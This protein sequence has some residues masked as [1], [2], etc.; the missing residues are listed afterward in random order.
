MD[1]FVLSE[2]KRVH[3]E[4]PMTDSPSDTTLYVSLPTI[5]KKTTRIRITGTRNI[6][7]SYTLKRK[8]TCF[9]GT[10]S[11]SVN[12]GRGSPPSSSKLPLHRRV[13]QTGKRP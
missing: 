6:P 7:G 9:V 2:P 11:G 4:E 12:Q 8:I 1:K 5:P 3:T 13:F 10:A